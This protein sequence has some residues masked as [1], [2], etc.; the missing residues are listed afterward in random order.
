M[1][2]R[3][4]FVEGHPS[5]LTELNRAKMVVDAHGEYVKYDDYHDMKMER[6]MLLEELDDMRWGLHGH[7]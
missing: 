1:A 2:R 3:Y 7:D 4:T 5:G 6:D